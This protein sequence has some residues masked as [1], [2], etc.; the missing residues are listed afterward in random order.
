MQNHLIPQHFLVPYAYSVCFS[1]HVFN[2]NN[3]IFH[4][5]TS[6]LTTDQTA[7]LFFIDSGVAQHHTDLTKKIKKY[8]SDQKNITLLTDPITLSGG[9]NCKNDPQVL[10]TLYRYFLDLGVDRQCCVVAIGGGAILDLVG[11]A[12]ATAHRGIR[13]I[14]MP[15]TVLAQNDSG[16]GVKNSVNLFERKNFLGTFAPPDAVICDFSLLDTLDERDKRAGMAEAIKV[17]L[18]RDAAFF[19]W[20]EHHSDALVAFE[21]TAVRESIIRSAQIHAKQIATGGDPFEKGNARPLD[22]G[23]WLAHKLE[24]MSAYT[25]RHGEAVALGMLLDSHYS[26]AIGALPEA[27]F[28]RITSCIRR[29]GF[30]LWHAHLAHQDEAG[31]A[32]VLSGLEEFREHLGGTL[33]ITLLQ[34]IGCGFEVNE[35]D[36]QLMQQSLDWCERFALNE[37]V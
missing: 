22:F 18:I 10:H 11:Y 8:I 26:F 15:S 9:E 19:T 6:A 25:V 5:V 28:I 1:E 24:V 31:K 29:L 4:E 20:L 27:D 13:H 14:R 37:T 23:H 7:L 34:S 12:A 16:V 17:S 3:P 30:P 33:S 21:A 32:L 36:H 35:I 2:T